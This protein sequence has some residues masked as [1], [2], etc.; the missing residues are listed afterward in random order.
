MNLL[1][2]KRK[3]GQLPKE[4]W[5]V[6]YVFQS[7]TEGVGE[8]KEHLIWDKR[9]HGRRIEPKPE[10]VIFGYDLKESPYRVQIAED[11][12][13]SQDN[14]LTCVVYGD[15]WTGATFASLDRTALEEARQKESLRIKERYTKS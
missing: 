3:K 5:G 8:I 14:H 4:D 9:V 6:I 10:A 7:N 13:V 1:D 15:P 2:Y 11:E 12:T